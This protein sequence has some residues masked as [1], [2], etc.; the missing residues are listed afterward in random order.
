MKFMVD[1]VH[2]LCG[3]MLAMAFEDV[4]KTQTC[5]LYS[6]GPLGST[7]FQ[8][9]QRMKEGDVTYKPKSWVLMVDWPS[10]GCLC[11][12]NPIATRCLFLVGIF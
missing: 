9:S 7:R 12:T 4:Y 5:H 11:R 2:E 6:F 1:V 10:S 3:C 8:G